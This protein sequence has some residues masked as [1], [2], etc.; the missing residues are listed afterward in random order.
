MFKVNTKVENLNFDGVNLEG[1]LE[2]I[3]WKKD[4]YNLLFIVPKLGT[5]ICDSEV[6]RLATLSN[7]FDSVNIIVGSLSSA[8]E[9]KK[10]K[11]EHK[12]P[13]S[14]ISLSEEWL[15]ENN[16][17]DPEFKL[18]IRATLITDPKN[19]LWHFGK[20][21]VLLPRSIKEV[22]RLCNSVKAISSGEKEVCT[23]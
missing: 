17:F 3:N 2:K 22:V 6:H 5:S 1:K 9:L 15:V 14:M 12:L 18:S 13:F 21:A 20:N 23:I 10:W 19:I 16:I 4:N 11:D 8:A 7:S